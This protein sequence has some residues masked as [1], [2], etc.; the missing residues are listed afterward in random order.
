MAA[1][2]RLKPPNKAAPH[3]RLAKP[4]K[5]RPP[6]AAETPPPALPAAG[7]GRRAKLALI[8]GGVAALA[9]GAGIAGYMLS[10]S[11]PEIVAPD[12]DAVA[13][14]TPAPRPP[15][16]GQ[17]RQGDLNEELWRRMGVRPE[18]P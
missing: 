4:A 17:V 8:A 2:A 12:I 9:L 14:P 18:G 13:P 11:E 1:P 10:A 15:P 5:G 6:D 3:A 7:L 16:I